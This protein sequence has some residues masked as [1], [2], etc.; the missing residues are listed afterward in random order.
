LESGHDYLSQ[1]GISRTT[2]ETFQIGY[3]AGR[4]CLGGR[5]VFPLHNERGELVGY[6]GRSVDGSEPKYKFPPGFAKS[7][8][9]FNVH[10]ATAAAGPSGGGATALGS[11]IVVEG[12]FDCL[13]V[14]QAGYPRVVALMG[15]SLSGRQEQLLRERFAKV[16]V[17]LDGDEAGRGATQRVLLQLGALARAAWVPTGRQPDQLS[18]EEIHSLVGGLL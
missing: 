7:Q 18:R 12:F 14:R 10:R 15:A 5:I 16:I 2:A 8:V 4:G 17:L 11:V 9:L 13:R 3:Y 1:R 6:A